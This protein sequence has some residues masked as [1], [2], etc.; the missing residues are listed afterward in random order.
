MHRVT[1]FRLSRKSLGGIQYSH[2]HY[3]HTLLSFV[4]H[5]DFRGHNPLLIKHGFSLAITTPV[6]V[7]RISSAPF[8]TRARWHLFSFISYLPPR[9]PV[10]LRTLLPHGTLFLLFYLPCAYDAAWIHSRVNVQSNHPRFPTSAGNPCHPHSLPSR[11]SV[12]VMEASLF[13]SFG[14]FPSTMS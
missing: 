5:P 1:R 2:Y 9:A 8:Q 12:S 6:T 4:R 10:S 13:F 11:T 14:I 3:A 7:P